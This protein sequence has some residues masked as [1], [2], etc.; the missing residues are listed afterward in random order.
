SALGSSGRA[1][2][3]ARSADRLTAGFAAR[4]ATTAAVAPAPVAASV[5]VVLFIVRIIPPRFRLGDR[6]P[7]A[8]G[9]NPALSAAP[10]EAE[11][12][13][14][15]IAEEQMVTVFRRY[16]RAELFQPFQL[17]F[18]RITAQVEMDAVLHDLL[19]WH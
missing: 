15:G 14:F 5:R 3:A 12:V 19:L 18:D 11:L 2:R 13:A 16:A 7:A 1:N 6:S 17:S 9:Q 10:G 4:A 8:W